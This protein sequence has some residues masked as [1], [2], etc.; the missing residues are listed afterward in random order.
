MLRLVVKVFEGYFVERIRRIEQRCDAVEEVAV[1]CREFVQ[2]DI[3]QCLQQF[4]CIALT[5]Q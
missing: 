2:G 1:F 3:E 4:F 5:L